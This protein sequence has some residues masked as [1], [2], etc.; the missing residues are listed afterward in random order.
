MHVKVIKV[1]NSKGLILNKSIIERYDISHEVMIEFAEDHLILR[2]SRRARQ[3]WEEQF[4]KAKAKEENE[5]LIPD[6]FEDE[7]LPSW[8]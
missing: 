1:G 6:V 5:L 4:I 3:D 2:P 8:S 7:D